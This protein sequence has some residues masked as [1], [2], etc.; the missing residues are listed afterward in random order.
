MSKVD[1]D[2]IRLLLTVARCG[3]FARAA[4]DLN[5]D[6]TTA[7]RR[8]RMLEQRAGTPLFARKTTGAQLTHAGHRLIEAAEEVDL[9]VGH[10]HHV[11]RGLAD[12]ET[13]VSIAT[14]DGIAA[15]LL[16]PAFV[17]DQPIDT[18]LRPTGRL[19]GLAS[20]EFRQLGAPADIEF[21]LV[22]PGE[23]VPRSSELRIRKIGTMQ[24]VPTATKAYLDKNGAPENFNELRRHRLLQNTANEVHPSL[25]P[26][27]DL[28]ESRSGGALMRA[29]TSVA[30]HHLTIMNAGVALLPNFSPVIDQ[31]VMLVPCAV[32]SMAI[33]IWLGAHPENL[34]NSVVRS[35]YDTIAAM[36][37]GSPWFSAV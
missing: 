27:N 14:T 3:S 15:Y 31:K 17:A 4:Q 7:S 33:E 21:V 29:P 6:Q 9:A 26:W 34:R 23:P 5:I 20:L 12:M 24:F 25:S 28:V 37:S 32:P 16:G 35:I 1:W 18:P 8:I 2:D 11:L 19:E 10:F 36:F 13:P 30:L 22:P